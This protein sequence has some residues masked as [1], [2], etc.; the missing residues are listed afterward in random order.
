MKKLIFFASFIL[1]SAFFPFCKDY[2][3][4]LRYGIDPSVDKSL[5]CE[6]IRLKGNNIDGNMPIG[7]GAGLPIVVDFP[8]TIEISAGVRVLIPYSISDPDKICKIYLQIEGANNYW[9][10]TV[11]KESGS[12]RP[13]FDIL[14]PLFVMDGDFNF[15]FSLEDCNGNVSEKYT[16]K[17]VVS[18]LASCGETISG[19]Y[20][21]TVRLFEMGEK[22]GAPRFTYDTYS[23]PD[24]IDI[25]YDGKWVASTGQL[26]D[27][28]KL[29]PDCSSGLNGFV[30]GDGEL[31]FTGYTPQK[32]RYVEVYISGCD[33]NTEWEITPFCPN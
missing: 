17:T 3:T 8:T 4:D 19:A 25:R 5:L 22:S 10:T 23:I 15:V 18:P 7:T 28:T 30:S 24:R 27:D 2:T 26:F 31:S 16:T 20:G 21:I 12:G 14:V 13:Y 29:L 33:V 1:I 32:T 11:L 6:A 9:E